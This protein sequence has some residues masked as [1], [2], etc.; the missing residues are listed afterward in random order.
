MTYPG[1][2]NGAGVYQQIINLMPPHKTYVEAFLGNGAI[3]KQK[4]PAQKNVGIERDFNVLENW[5]GKEITNLK[6]IWGNA[7]D[8]LKTATGW[9]DDPDLQQ[10]LIYLDP[11]Y[12][13]SVRKSKSKIYNC[14]MM[15][16][17]EHRALLRTILDLPCMVLISG[18]DSELYNDYLRTWRTHEFKTTNRAGDHVT[19]K[20]WLNFPEPAELHDYSFLGTNFRERQNIKRVKKRWKNKLAN[21]D[22]QTR[23]ALLSALE[24]FKTG[25]ARQN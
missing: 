17:D 13:Q 14:E 19:E 11:P 7:L 22:S 4:R 23:F 8:F 2:K 20:V 3:I 16:D 21:M 12:L 15:S 24:E 9:L 6:L 18:Y 10:T 5:S 25:A 1:G